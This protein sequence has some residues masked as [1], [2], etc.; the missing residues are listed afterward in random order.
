MRS[1]SIFVFAPSRRFVLRIQIS[2]FAIYVYYI[3]LPEENLWHVCETTMLRFVRAECMVSLYRK[4]SRISWEICTRRAALE[5]GH[6]E[7][8]D[9]LSPLYNSF[10]RIC[11]HKHEKFIVKMI[12]VILKI[13]IVSH[14]YTY[15]SSHWQSAPYILRY[16]SW[17][18]C[19]TSKPIRH[20]QCIYSKEK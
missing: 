20:L 10:L 11:F 4:M 1:C 6:F 3:H 14:V 7:E 5:V 19:R 13:I 2:S 18:I 17:L 16:S 12:L 9:S 8:S 15:V